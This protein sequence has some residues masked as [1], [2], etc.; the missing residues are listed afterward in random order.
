VESVDLAIVHGLDDEPI[1]HHPEEAHLVVGREGPKLSSGGGVQ[2]IEEEVF[3]A[4]VDD[5]TGDVELV[6]LAADREL[7]ES[8]SGGGVQGEDLLV[9]GAE[10]DP[11]VRNDQRRLRL[12]VVRSTY[13]SWTSHL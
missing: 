4:R 7:P 13:V 10:L 5:A 3:A 9:V 11:A 6:G 1:A 2:G 8:G 12:A